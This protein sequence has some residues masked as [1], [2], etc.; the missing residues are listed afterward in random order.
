MRMA[1]TK[2]GVQNRKSKRDQKRSLS[3]LQD[4]L[5]KKSAA[6]PE[7]GTKKALVE[8]AKMKKIEKAEKRRRRKDAKDAKKEAALEQKEAAAYALQKE[9]AAIAKQQ[10]LEA[11]KAAA[12]ARAKPTS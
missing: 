11:V 2:V 8:A 3:S 5:K 12:A 7:P 10:R 9:E 4:T 1:K 6:L